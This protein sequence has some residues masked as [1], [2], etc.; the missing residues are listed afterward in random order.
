MIKHGHIS[1]TTAA[2]IATAEPPPFL[3]ENAA[4]AIS[5]ANAP[6]CATCR[7]LVSLTDKGMVKVHFASPTDTRPCPGSY[8]AWNG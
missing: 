7:R 6:L 1:K 8:Q 3:Q 5:E 4:Q 2:S